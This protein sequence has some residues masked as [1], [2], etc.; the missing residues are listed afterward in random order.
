MPARQESPASQT[1]QS[2]PPSPHA[3]ALGV[4]TQ[5]RSA[6]QQ[7]K[8]QLLESQRSFTH[9]PERQVSSAAQDRQTS[10]TLP[11]ARGVVPGWHT[12]SGSRHPS[13]ASP[14]QAP[15]SQRSPAPQGAQKARGGPQASARMPPAHCPS[16]RQQEEV[17]AQAPPP[18]SARPASGA[19]AKHS[20]S[21]HTSLVLQRAQGAPPS[22][23]AVRRVPTTQ[24]PELSQHPVQVDAS[25]GRVQAGPR[26]AAAAT[27][28]KTGSHH[29]MEGPTLAGRCPGANVP[30]RI[31]PMRAVA[32]LLLAGLSASCGCGQASLSSRYGELVVVERDTVGRE[33]FLRDATVRLPPVAMS[34]VGEHPVPV[35]NLGQESVTITAATRLEG[36]EA[37]SL[38]GAVGLAIDALA[39]ATLPARFA[40]LQ[41]ADA[42]LPE[43]PARARFSLALSGARPG[44][45]ELLLELT[46]TGVARDCY[47]PGTL[48][49]GEVPLQQAVTLPVS[50]AHERL[51]PARA[52]RGAVEGADAAFFS[53]EG[54][55]A[56]EVAPGVAASFPVR[57]G[58]LEE[59]EYRAQVT[60]QR[61][62]GCPAATVTLVGR[63]SDEALT[64]SPTRLD[65]GRLPLEV[66][67]TREVTIVNRSGANLSL[68][69]S[70]TGA[71]FALAGAA[72]LAVP[73]RGSAVVTVACAPT[74]LGPR[75]GTLALELGTSPLTL[76]RIEL[77][78]IGGGPRIR[79]DPNPLQFGLVQWAASAR[80]TSATAVRRRLVVQNVG[81]APLAPGDT[82][83]NLRLGRGGSPP[84]FSVVPG[85]TG[86]R[87]EE[88]TVAL[89]TPAPADGLPA[90]A[91]QNL[92]EF[93]V[94]L[95]ATS[96]SEKRATL[97]VYSNDAK[98]P[99]LAVPLLAQPRNAETC[100]LRV[101]PAGVNFGPTPRGGTATREVRLTNLGQ[102]G[103]MCLISGIELGPGSDP[104]FLVTDPLVPSRLIAPGSSAVVRVSASV[105]LT[106]AIGQYLRGTL[107]FTVSGQ[108]GPTELPVDLQVS[109]CL[110]ADPPVLD[111]GIVREGCTSGGKPLTL[112]N[113]CS[114][115]V[116]VEPFTVPAPFRLTSAG[117]A[118]FTLHPGQQ[119]ALTL[120]VAPTTSAPY[121]EALELQY[122]EG[123]R[124]FS[125]GVQLKA[126]ATVA[127]E[128]TDRWVQGGAAVDILFVIDD[129]CS[130]ADEQQA[131]AANFQAFMADAATGIADWRIGVTTTDTFSVQGRLLGTVGNPTVLTPVTP[132]VQQ[133]FASKVNVGTNGSGYE[134]P[135]AAMVAAVT[136][137]NL[138]GPNAGFLRPRTPLAVII[139]TDAEEQSPSTPGSYLATLRAAK[140]G[141][142]DLVNVS[143]VGPFSQQTG[144]FLDGPVDT[145]RYSAVVDDSNGVKADIC[146]TDWATD[147]RAISRAVFGGQARF[148]LTGRPDVNAGISVTVDG[149]PRSTG[150]RYDAT[151][152][153]IVF[154]SP[155]A[156]NAV[157]EA[158]WRAACF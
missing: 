34:A 82:S 55:E 127:G 144:C 49:F 29:R 138:S 153:A 41:A 50:L 150:W 95:A 68:A 21:R 13:H 31:A 56:L 157:V 142:A 9:A 64:W 74:A 122:Q 78:C 39:D 119:Q 53:V 105:P 125:T 83:H 90:I 5:V 28:I 3:D 89:R 139:V 88:F 72:P 38:E 44:E 79:V 4:V 129:S 97:L 65:F 22:P 132:N 141:R 147:L 14:T 103:N 145:G 84:W 47:L 85:N 20:P 91:G 118:G 112:Y 81:T 11:H 104:A 61:D 69:A 117:G 19:A 45:E 87:A 136:E 121:D 114:V 107:R 71:D 133:L 40:P 6:R 92:L 152:N 156:P 154:S 12:P 67:A 140:G 30:A 59:R 109:R 24:S 73:A 101:E 35:R 120:A 42:T 32:L 151:T 15:A 18:A 137:P 100:L 57:F 51:L 98:E 116:V 33:Y 43:V 115:P 46:A 2:A 63:G 135:F 66:S 80:A 130:M 148:T 76:P 96:A 108:S 16:G 102:D 94:T 27:T 23:H 134:Q 54:P 155:P 48:D 52:T 58:P 113:L 146:T 158:T 126:T 75:T 26:V 99:V 10:P 128:Q 62:P 143:V 131:L 77:A 110:V 106:A 25:Q 37:L 8:R 17:Q 123:G 149:Q 124:P 1:S 36:D 7:P 93:D 60:L 86:T 111:F 70:V